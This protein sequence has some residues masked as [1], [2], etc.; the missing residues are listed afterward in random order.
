MAQ[1]GYD[2][3]QALAERGGHPALGELPTVG[4]RRM[5]LQ[6]ERGGISLHLPNQEVV[7]RPDG[8]E[9]V[10]EAPLR[11]EQWNEQISLLT[12]M[13]AAELMLEAG[14][15]L[16]RTL[17]PPPEFVV[18]ALGRSARGLGVDWPKATRGLRRRS[19]PVWT[20][21]CPPTPR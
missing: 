20:R 2:E 16:L 11:I 13:V 17:P 5:A 12:G 9:V 1:L 8:Y 4:E 10:F 6:A 15:G 18:R 7:E 21:P 19:W 3:G 14:T